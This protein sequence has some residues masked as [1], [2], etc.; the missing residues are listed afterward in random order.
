MKSIQINKGDPINKDH[1]E[2]EKDRER[3][4]WGRE[5]ERNTPVG[6]NGMG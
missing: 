1:K 3:K 5:R 6:E 2:Q 4:I